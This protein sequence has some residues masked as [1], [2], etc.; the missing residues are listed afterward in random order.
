MLKS[1]EHDYVLS[2]LDEEILKE[3]EKGGFVNR[4]KKELQDRKDTMQVKLSEYFAERIA[5]STYI[6]AIRESVEKVKNARGIGT[7]D[8]L[9]KDL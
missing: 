3:Q 6:D 2:R 5:F 4:R 1:F 8:E 7:F 9:K